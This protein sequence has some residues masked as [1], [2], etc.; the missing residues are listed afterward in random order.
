MVTKNEHTCGHPSPPEW[1]PEVGVSSTTCAMQYPDKRK[2]IH[3]MRGKSQE[4]SRSS[5]TLSEQQHKL[6]LC[7]V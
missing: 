5:W 2:R 7:A 4:L 1:L 3:L 6:G